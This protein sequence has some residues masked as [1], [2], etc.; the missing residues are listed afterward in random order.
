V[1]RK[2]WMVVLLFE[3]GVVEGGVGSE[4]EIEEEEEEAMKSIAP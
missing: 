3:V 2:P 4:S 1:R